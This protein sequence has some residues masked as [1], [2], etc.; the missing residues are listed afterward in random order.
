[1][2]GK[3]VSRGR[4]FR[5]DSCP[6]EKAS[7]SL[8]SPA[9]RPC[10]PRLTATEGPRKSRHASC[11]PEAPAPAP[12]EHRKLARRRLPPLLAGEG[13]GGVLWLL[14]A[15]SALLYPGAPMARRVGGG[16]PAG[17]PAWMPASFSPAQDVLSKKPVAC[18]RTRKAGCLEGAPSGWR[19]SLVPFSL[20]TQRE[21]NSATGRWTKPLCR[22]R[23]VDESPPQ[24]SLGAEPKGCREHPPVTPAL[25]RW[26]EGEAGCSRRAN[27]RRQ[28]AERPTP[29]DNRKNSL[30]SG[31]L[32]TRTALTRNT[33]LASAGATVG[34]ARKLAPV[35]GRSPPGTTITSTLPGS[36]AMLASG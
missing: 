31:S 28:R 5:P 18:P 14:R 20:G 16:K 3:C 2:D 13:W 10:R 36:W 9:A 24:A 11:V 33:A 7:P 26:G 22:W 25:P 19:F 15:G 30:I 1:M 12:A 27:L 35:G 34:M 4:A 21:R 32:R 8:A 6:V 29:Y 23:Q 17:W